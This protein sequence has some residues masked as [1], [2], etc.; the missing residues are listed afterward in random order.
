MR[1]EIDLQGQGF[2]Q[3]PVIPGYTHPTLPDPALSN[4]PTLSSFQHPTLT[5]HQPNTMDRSHHK[6]MM[7]QTVLRQYFCIA[8]TTCIMCPPCGYWSLYQAFKVDDMIDRDNFLGAERL[9]RKIK[10]YSI[11]IMV[12]GVF[13]VSLTVAVFFLLLKKF[14]D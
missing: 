12:V 8:L 10:R 6:F 1:E 3:P 5:S 11:I 9:A 14:K 4:H 2:L 13:W 7:N